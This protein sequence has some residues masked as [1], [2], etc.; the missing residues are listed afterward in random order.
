[1]AEQKTVAELMARLNPKSNM[2]DSDFPFGSGKSIPI[3]TDQDIAAA[4]GMAHIPE[5]ARYLARL[6]YAQQAHLARDAA[7]SLY[8]TMMDRGLDD[9]IKTKTHRSGLILD[10]AKLA[11]AEY[12]G[13]HICPMCN[14]VKSVE[15]DAKIVECVECVG[16]GIKPWSLRSRSAFVGM[17]HMT[18][19]RIWDDRLK[20]FLDQLALWDSIAVRAIANRLFKT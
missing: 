15:V 14:G 20:T 6:K 17:N 13:S 7:V 10:M 9:W 4:M 18:W 1:M 8:M 2:P 11:V 12:V 16:T 19:M 3:F 5:G